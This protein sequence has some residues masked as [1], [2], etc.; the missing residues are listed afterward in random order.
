M[1]LEYDKRSWIALRHNLDILQVLAAFG[2]TAIVTFGAIIFGYLASALPEDYLNEADVIA[3]EVINR[4]RILGDCGRFFRRFI[5]RI[6]PNFKARRPLTRAQKEKA[7]ERFILTLSDQQL[8]TGLAVLVGAF[9]NHCRLSIYEFNVVIALAWFSSLTH[10]AT[11]DV[12]QKYFLENAVVRDYRVIGMVIVL[13]L[14]MAAQ[15]LSLFYDPY[16]SPV[17]IQ[18]LIP[19]FPGYNDP[20]SVVSIFGLIFT[21]LYLVFSYANRI[22]RLYKPTSESLAQKLVPSLYLS[23]GRYTHFANDLTKLERL[24]VLRAAC[25]A[26]LQVSEINEVKVERVSSLK[27]FMPLC[28]SIW[29]YQDSFLSRIGALFFS[30]SY[31]ISQV[32]VSRFADAPA[33]KES[34]RRWDFGQIVPIVLLSL[35][36]LAAAEIYYGT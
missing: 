19:G 2:L 1:D 26:C 25:E 23:L 3:I 20:I 28:R 11:L 30:L 21:I 13:T 24:E 31:G 27:L 34:S 6:F 32:V 5:Y 12:L 18:C 36:M 10:L 8:V 9:S 15:V 29:S 14:L 33:M 7:L 16:N 35:P 4:S 17:P 22:R